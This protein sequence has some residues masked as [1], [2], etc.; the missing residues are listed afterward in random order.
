MDHT[1]QRGNRNM[2]TTEQLA[3]F[4]AGVRYQDIPRAV[5]ANAELAIMDSVA[6]VYAGLGET[7]VALVTRAAL[8]EGAAG[9]A[10][11]IGS[12]RKTSASAAALANGAAAHALD[13]DSISLTVSGFVASPVLFALLA[14]AEA[15]SAPVSGRRLLQAFVAGW[16]T[17]AAIARGL[18]VHHYAKGW[19]STATLGH[20]G[21]AAAASRL[22]DLD[23]AATRSALGI[24]ASEASGLRTMIG[25]M[26]NPFHVGKA[27]RNGVFAAQLARDGFT[28][29]AGVIE[30]A[31]GFAVAFNGTGG[32][33]LAR[34]TDALG[35]RWDL[36]DPGLVIKVYPC[37]GLVHSAI[38]AALDL[39]AELA[40]NA[41]DI[42]QV[43]VAVHALVPPTMKFHS[44]ATGYEA[45]FSTEFC[46]ATALLE[47]AVR[48]EHFTD[49]RTRDG[50][51]TALMP[52]V[53]M[54]VHP[55]L[56]DASTFLEKEFSE[57]TIG[58]KD[59]RSLRRRVNRIANR[60]SRG[61]PADIALIRAKAADCIAASGRA[62]QAA[63]ALALLEQLPRIA[64]I[65][66]IMAHLS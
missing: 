40:I 65:R 22:L 64:D 2:G 39:R 17:E 36:V 35:T 57:V 32:F 34:M 44:P 7:S 31:S 12:A 58:L 59:G 5:L 49:A 1:G 26:T 62:A 47:G 28:A 16:E 30:H 6:T 54:V 52:R 33:D 18:G 27:A 20:F 9:P 60:G 45:K 38:D 13:Y 8:R 46:I 3:E 63:Q 4:A 14:L 10:T 56:R 29:E 51:M 53:R 41:D 11:V 19:H 25:N 23:V 48:L 21:A 42:G 50:A 37:C 43:E 66:E 24:A 15:E 55:D 61:R